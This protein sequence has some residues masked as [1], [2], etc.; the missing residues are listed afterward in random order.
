MTSL[1]KLMI[2]L[3][4][5][6]PLLPQGYRKQTF[7]AILKLILGISSNRATLKTFLSHVGKTTI[8]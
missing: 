7:F 5:C 8:C 2:L 3:F 6:F 4:E 1:E